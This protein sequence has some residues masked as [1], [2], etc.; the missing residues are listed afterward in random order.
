MDFKIGMAESHKLSLSY[1][2]DDIGNNKLYISGFQE[3]LDNEWPRL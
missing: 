2:Y 1:F 3:L